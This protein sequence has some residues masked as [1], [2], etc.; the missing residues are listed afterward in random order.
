MEERGDDQGYECAEGV[1]D[2]DTGT[3]T[4]RCLVDSYSLGNLPSRPSVSSVTPTTQQ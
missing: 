2:G 3:V 4:Y 1:M